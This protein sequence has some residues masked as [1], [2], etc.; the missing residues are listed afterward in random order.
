MKANFIISCL[1]NQRTWQQ[2]LISFEN[3][4]YEDDQSNV[5]KMRIKDKV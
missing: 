3:L 1:D 2:Y 5:Q 4:V